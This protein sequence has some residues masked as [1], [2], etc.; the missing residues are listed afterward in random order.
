MSEAGAVKPFRFHTRLYLPV[1]T[2]LRARN[3]SELL[4]HLRSVPDSVIFHHT[5]HF[6]QQHQ[7]LSPEPPNDF[8]YWV[9]HA[10][11]ENDLAEKL[12]S[13]NTCEFTNLAALRERIIK[14]MEADEMRA[15]SGRQAAQAH[16][17]DEFHFMKSVSLIFPTP[18]T[19]GNL[20]EF[21][22]ALEKVS[23]HSLY[24]HIFESKLRLG[25]ET[26]DF[27]L[28]MEKELG[29]KGL[30]AKIRKLDPYNYTMEGLRKQIIRLVSG[31]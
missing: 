29:E 10:L 2:G 15:K 4:R 3:A 13:I 31:S 11:N 22:A 23:I 30:A 17:G 19:A 24:F 9:K 25:K 18:Y 7:Y 21:A 26:N 16:E 14:V 20:A 5:H 8:A 27:S 6:L 12:A 28:W 1:L